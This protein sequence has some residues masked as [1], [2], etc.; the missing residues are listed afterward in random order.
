[1]RYL[2][3]I[4]NPFIWGANVLGYFNHLDMYR[5]SEYEPYDFDRDWKYF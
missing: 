3:K 1:M 2:L 5:D 4:L